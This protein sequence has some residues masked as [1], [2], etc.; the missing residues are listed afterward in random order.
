MRSGGQLGVIETKKMENRGI[1]IV[2]V[3]LVLDGV[4]AEVIGL[5]EL[6]STFHTAT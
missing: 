6:N 5:A 3:N 4:E 2:D 1:E